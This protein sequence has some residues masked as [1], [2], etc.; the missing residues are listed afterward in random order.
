MKASSRR[1]AAKNPTTQRVQ[2]GPPH[3]STGVGHSGTALNIDRWAKEVLMF[4]RG[5]SL[6]R[7]TLGGQN[8]YWPVSSERRTTPPRRSKPI[9]NTY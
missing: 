3:N 4:I 1:G 5:T 2:Y 9:Y 8:R 6:G 7:R